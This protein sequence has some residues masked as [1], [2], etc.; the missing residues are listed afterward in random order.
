VTPPP[1]RTRSSTRRSRRATPSPS[2]VQWTG[3]DRVR[4]PVTDLGAHGHGLARHDGQPLYIPDALPGETVEV[5]IVDRVGDGW[6]AE[7]LSHLDPSPDRVEPVCPHFGPCGGCTLQH[8]RP[9]AQAAWKRQQII[10]AVTKRGLPVPDVDPVVAIPPGHRRRCTLG[11]RRTA[12]AVLL[13][14]HG[15]DSHRL[16]DVHTCPMVAS[17]LFVLFASLRALL[18]DITGAGDA[19][20]AILTLTDTGADCTLTLDRPPTLAIRERLA[21]FAEDADLARLGWLS[22]GTV[23]PVVERRPPTVLMAG[24]PV[25]LPPLAFLQPSREGA[26][27]IIEAVRA[28]L[29]ASDGAALDLYA[30]MGTVTFPLAAEGRAVHAVDENADSIA[31]LSAAV[32]PGQPI[33]TAVRNLDSDPVGGA[34]L[35]AFEAVVFDPP[36]AGARAQATALASD[37]PPHIVAVSCRPATFARDARILVDAGYA[38]GRITTIDQ[39]PWAAHVE[40]VAGFERRP[41]A[42]LSD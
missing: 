33:T 5:R 37:G 36:R 40:L 2:R 31:A 1:N 20:Q 19:G 34:A 8:L 28:R 18:E 6:R 14:F 13:G 9:A 24:T 30:G 27:A 32:A 10:D 12:R 25:R 4:V 38:L 16:E 15:Q 26:E 39:F 35:H 11:W 7:V 21:A 3:P 41:A 17:D 29:P 22:N 42:A 23:E